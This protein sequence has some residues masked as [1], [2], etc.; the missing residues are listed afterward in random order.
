MAQLMGIIGLFHL[1]DTYLYTRNT[2]LN[3]G[4]YHVCYVMSLSIATFIKS[5]G[6]VKSRYTIVHMIHFEI[7]F[8][9]RE[10]FQILRFI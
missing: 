1:G 8:Y 3:C 2:T 5:E 4:A 6:N 9:L 7:C 10:M